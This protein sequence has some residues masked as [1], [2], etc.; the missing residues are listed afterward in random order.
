MWEQFLAGTLPGLRAGRSVLRL[1]PSSPRCKL[2]A[3]PFS[4]VGGRI[5]RWVGKGPWERNP[6]F[7]SFCGDW[8]AKQGP[9]GAEVEL[10]LLFAD[11]RGS[12]ALAS[13]MA[14]AKYADVINRFF[15][16]GTDVFVRH[17]AILDQLVGDEVIGLFL[18]GYAGQDHARRAIEA[19]RALL[20]ATGHEPG[21]EPWIPVGIGVHTGVTFVGAMGTQGGFTDFTA[22]GA[23]VN[24]TA[25]LSASAAAGEILVSDA[26]SGAAALDVGG[27]EGRRLDLKGIPEPVPVR[28]LRSA[29]SFL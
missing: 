26:A 11:V 17:G 25:R 21:R 1:I 10:T 9:G 2:C 5:L 29:P 7:C 12:T 6:R 18:P 3:S 14:P 28:V 24:T 23:S 13:S 22:I 27:L 19:A 20:A 15:R 4:G 8:I 16:V